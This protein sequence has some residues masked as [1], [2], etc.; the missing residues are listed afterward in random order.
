[1]RMSY[2]KGIRVRAKA[3]TLGVIDELFR[4]IQKWL[5]TNFLD[6]FCD[7]NFK[8]AFSCFVFIVCIKCGIQFKRSSKTCR[9]N[10][11]LEAIQT[12]FGC[13]W[14]HKLR[15][16][17]RFREFRR[18]F[19]LIPDLLLKKA[20]LISMHLFRAQMLGW[21]VLFTVLW[22]AF[23]T[24]ASDRH[25]LLICRVAFSNLHLHQSNYKNH[26]KHQGVQRFAHERKKRAPGTV[27]YIFHIP[28]VK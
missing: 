26:S 4:C 1:M 23:S 2:L 22:S 15:I 24:L 17:Y 3:M 7:L 19:G 28:L 20:L 6:H 14:I 16:L 9:E 25:D 11:E 21:H 13:K 5:Q 27:Y 8:S 12:Y 18:T 10:L